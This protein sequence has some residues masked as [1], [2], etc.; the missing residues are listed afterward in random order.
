MK[1]TI[2]TLDKGIIEG[3]CNVEKE[4]WAS[5]Q[6]KAFNKLASKVVIKGFRPGKAP[7]RFLRER[8]SKTQIFNE[9]VE[10]V[11]TPVYTS[12]LVE[13]KLQPFSRPNVDI[14]KLSDDELQVK[15][16]VTL[17]PKVTLAAHSGLTAEKKVEGVTD[18]EVEE[19]INKRLANSANLVSVDRPSIKGDTVIL[20]FV[21]SMDGEKFDGGSANNY[22]L[23]LGSNSFVPGFEDALIGVKAGDTKDVNIVFPAQYV[24]ELAGKPA[25]F[26]CVIHEIK[27]KVI[28]ALS[29]D[30][31][32]DFGI[33][34]VETVDAMKE[35]QMKS[36]AESKARQADEDYYNALV[37]QIV[38]SSEVEIADSILNQEAATQE[39][40]TK[41]Q[42]ESNGLTFEQYLEITGQKE[43][44]LKATLK[45]SSEANLKRYLVLQELAHAEHLDV[46][47]AELDTEIAKLADQY[48]MGVED[49]KKAL[50]NL[51]NYRESIRSRKVREWI[52]A[53]NGVAGAAAPKKG[54]EAAP[55]KA[56]AKKAATAK[57]ASSKKEAK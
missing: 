2:K 46:S 49:V 50:G 21:G 43:E 30:S 14:T 29:D 3:V 41:K 19:A 56:P 12:F 1:S 17:F 23:E 10:E 27:E 44:D 42:V 51:D 47:D 8:I 54:D 36:L 13:N 40:N 26:H 4:L 22:E 15:F 5:A 39:E 48:K 7:E 6:K 35:Y 37:D 32:K 34:G 24:K 9:A 45:K 31:V 28:P 16:T 38:D 55:K 18:K 57:K 20:D 53:N 11:L 33:K 52:I 25:T